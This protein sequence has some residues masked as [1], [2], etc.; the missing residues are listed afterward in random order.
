MAGFKGQAENSLDSKGR[1]P[2]PAKMRRAL[3][4][5]AKETFVATRGE[6]Q[7]VV[8]YPL[9]YWEG[10]IE[11]RMRGLNMFNQ[12]DRV[13]VRQL[14][15]WADEVTMDGQGRIAVPKPLVEFAGLQ[16][17]EKALVIGAFDRLEVWD[18]TVFE[19]HIND[20]PDYESLAERV[21]G[22]I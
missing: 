22:G 18:P 11:P 13:F 20:Q 2:V 12:E 16:P 6:E 9:D 7:C 4:P 15:R 10:E 14:N 5:D 8:L 3:S 1:L 19:S 21:M 17:G